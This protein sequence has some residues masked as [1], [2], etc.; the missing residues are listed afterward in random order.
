VVYPEAIIG[1]ELLHS[2]KDIMRD[3]MMNLG[4]GISTNMMSE[5]N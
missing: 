5:E 2:E 4:V 1:W 3:T